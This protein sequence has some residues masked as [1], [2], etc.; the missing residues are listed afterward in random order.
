MF[1]RRASTDAPP[2][3]RRADERAATRVTTFASPS[4]PSEGTERSWN[5]AL[6]AEFP[7][8]EACV[9][10]SFAGA[11][12]RMTALGNVLLA[13]ISSSE[14]RVRY[15]PGGRW[16]DMVCVL[17]QVHGEARVQHAGAASRLVPGD[18]LLVDSDRALALEFSGPYEQRFAVVPRWRLG[19]LGRDAFARPASGR[20]A[21]NRLLAANLE[22]LVGVA[23]E[24]SADQNKL[25]I[26]SLI[27]LLQLSTLVTDA[28]L[29]GTRVER[30]L[31]F[32]DDALGDPALTPRAVADAQ[33]V[34]RRFLDELFREAGTTVEQ[35]IW[36][37]RL[38][39]ARSLLLE[40]EGKTVLGV[41][42]EVGFVSASHFSRAYRR[43]FGHRPTETMRTRPRVRTR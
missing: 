23:S 41:A 6:G 32:I 31:R 20:I 40:D 21:A 39:R 17:L 7:G 10:A 35:T 33:G 38:Q 16:D 11:R 28:K 42:L 9:G 30:A 12:F 5:R 8:A 25:A 3:S 43:R 37:Q 24:L 22:A 27:A 34:S 36:E 4:C 15:T 29:S 2:G 13:E 1:A 26:D 18:L 14:Q 19:R